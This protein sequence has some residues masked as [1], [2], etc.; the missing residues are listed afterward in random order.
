MRSSAALFA[1]TR[2][3]G[4]EGGEP[5]VGE[6]STIPGHPASPPAIHRL[7]RLARIANHLPGRISTVRIAGCALLDQP[8]VPIAEVTHS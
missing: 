3:A 8:P 2:G 6:T 7:R 5:S 4:F 1:P